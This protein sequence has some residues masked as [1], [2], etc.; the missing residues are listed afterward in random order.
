M[1]F[2]N[3]VKKTKLQTAQIKQKLKTSKDLQAILLLVFWTFGSRILG[4]VRSFLVLRM[5]TIDSEIFNSSFV[6]SEAITSFFIL[7]S[8]TVAILP[9]MIKLQENEKENLQNNVDQMDDKTQAENSNLEN[10]DQNLEKEK[11]LEEESDNYNFSSKSQDRK[12]TKDFQ[13]QKTELISEKTKT[14]RKSVV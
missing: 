14:D 1:N 13:S 7:G 9:Q 2:S 6:L 12:N 5:P 11:C 8:I 4:F 10:L 3:F